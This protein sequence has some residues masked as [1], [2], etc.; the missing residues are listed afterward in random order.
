MSRHVFVIDEIL[1][2]LTAVDVPTRYVTQF[3]ARAE[4]ITRGRPEVGVDDVWVSSGFG[5]ASQRGLV[6][7]TVNDQRTQMDTKKAREIGL[8]LIQAAEAGESD[9]IFVTFLKES[10]FT[11]SPEIIGQLLVRLREIRQGSKDGVRPS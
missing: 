9:E 6:E 8:M 10:G 7:L 5:T 11:D 4:Q 3:R 1:A 2:I